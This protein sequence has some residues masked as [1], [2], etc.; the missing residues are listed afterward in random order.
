MDLNHFCVVKYLI[1]HTNLFLLLPLMT[2]HLHLVGHDGALTSK[3]NR[4]IFVTLESK[5]TISISVC[6]FFFLL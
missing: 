4:S 5:K 1:G 3:D 2:H 6:T